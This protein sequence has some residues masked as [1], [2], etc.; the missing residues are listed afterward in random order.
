M[1]LKDDVR[2]PYGG[3]LWTAQESECKGLP[4]IPVEA[5]RAHIGKMRAAAGEC[6]DQWDAGYDYALCKLISELEGL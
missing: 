2:Y 6:I 5:L 4:V 3:Y 1:S